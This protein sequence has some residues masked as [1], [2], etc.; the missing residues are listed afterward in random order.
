MSDNRTSVLQ[1]L[2]KQSKIVPKGSKIVE[3]HHKIQNHTKYLKQHRGPKYILHIWSI[4]K[5]TACG[6]PLKCG[7]LDYGCLHLVVPPVPRLWY[8]GPPN[9]IT[10]LSESNHV[11]ESIL[12][13]VRWKQI[14]VEYENCLNILLFLSLHIPTNNCYHV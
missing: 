7:T 6:T 2:L 10:S 11:H 14:S 9:C 12:R 4:K 8:L 1:S 5:S 3:Q 13:Y